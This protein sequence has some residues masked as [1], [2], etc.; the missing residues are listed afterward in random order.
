MY[1]VLSLT[2][3]YITK[4]EVSDADFGVYKLKFRVFSP[5][6]FLHLFF[7]Q[8]QLH[9]A[10]RHIFEAAALLL[11]VDYQAADHELEGGGE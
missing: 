3:F 7:R 6:L 10:H 1:R 8:I 2:H 4:G 9:I 11:S 5:P